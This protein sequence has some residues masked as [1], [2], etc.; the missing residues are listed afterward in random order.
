MSEWEKLEEKLVRLEEELRTLEA[1]R[2]AGRV[3]FM[4]EILDEAGR[5]RA[6]LATGHGGTVSLNLLDEENRPRA[7]IG[8]M[9]SGPAVFLLDEQGTKRLEVQLAADGSPGVILREVGG[10]VR[11]DGSV[12]NTPTLGLLNADGSAAGMLF[13]APDGTGITLARE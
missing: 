7:A 3:L 4:A 1:T 9:A 12:V 6:M 10:Q 11:I 8:L 2:A 5:T 13:V